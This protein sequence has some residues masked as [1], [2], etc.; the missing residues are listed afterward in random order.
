M[1]HYTIISKSLCHKGC[2]NCQLDLT[3]FPG[4]YFPV[5]V[6][7]WNTYFQNP[8]GETVPMHSVCTLSGSALC[9]AGPPPDL[10]THSQ[11]LVH[12]ACSAPNSQGRFMHDREKVQFK[13]YAGT[14]SVLLF[15]FHFH[16]TPPQA[17]P[18][19]SLIC[20]QLNPDTPQMESCTQ[21]IK[22][23]Q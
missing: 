13:F 8:S 17:S 1:F 6:K 14:A 12:S 23:R 19:L 20:L 3:I 18:A 10:Q 9:A 21:T 4:L 2:Q 7:G 11:W 15:L 22:M 16:F 5:N